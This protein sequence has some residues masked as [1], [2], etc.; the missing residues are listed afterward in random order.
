ME[1]EGPLALFR[2]LVEKTHGCT[3]ETSCKVERG[4]VRA[5]RY[6]LFYHGEHRALFLDRVMGLFDEVGRTEK[7]GLDRDLLRRFLGREADLTGVRKVVT[8]IDLHPDRSRS[9]LKVW[10]ILGDAPALARRAI[11]LHG[12]SRT[13]NVLRLHDELLIGFDLRFDGTSGI[14]IYPDVRAEQAKDRTVRARLGRVLSARAIEAMKECVWTH[15][16]LAKHNADTVLQFHPADPGA[17]L[18]RY[19]P[20]L[21]VK[22]LGRAYAGRRLLDMVASMPDGELAA[23]DVKTYALYWMPADS[24]G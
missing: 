15:V 11:A 17:F 5:A 12:D 2:R 8:G 6:N 13:V 22:R 9:R 18:A 21:A 3:L 14:K 4:E 7:R 16:Y 10:F 24:P 23:G 19:L 1:T 20:G